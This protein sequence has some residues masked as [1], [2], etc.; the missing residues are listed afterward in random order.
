MADNN[1][2]ASLTLDGQAANAVIYQRRVDQEFKR[3]AAAEGRS[4]YVGDD[5]PLVRDAVKHV[6]LLPWM[7]HMLGLFTAQNQVFG[8][9]L[10]MPEA[11]ILYSAWSYESAE[12]S[13]V[14]SVSSTLVVKARSGEN[15]LDLRVTQYASLVYDMNLE[16]HLSFTYAFD[17]DVGGDVRVSA[18][19]ETEQ[20]D[21]ELLPM[22]QPS[23]ATRALGRILDGTFQL[24]W[25][26]ERD[27]R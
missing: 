7:Q 16:P 27:A 14:P 13:E 6:A 4:L 1:A 22:D 17:L 8:L 20:F 15:T 19:A 18:D 10:P 25:L 21:K 2:D 9:T 12:H 5:I 3:M 24:I 23:Q 11:W 26:E